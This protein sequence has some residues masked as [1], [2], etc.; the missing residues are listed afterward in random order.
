M[1]PK[2][3]GDTVRKRDQGL[4]LALSGDQEALGRLLASYMPRARL[5]L[6]NE[7][8][9]APGAQRTLRGARCDLTT[10][11]HRLDVGCM[12]EGAKRAA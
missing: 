7:V 12:E 9:A 8:G 6:R 2:G 4:Q 1:E 5:R 11:R 3:D 10:T